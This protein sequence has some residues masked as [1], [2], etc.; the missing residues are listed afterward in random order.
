MKFTPAF[1]AEEML[2]I[3]RKDMPFALILSHRVKS[4]S[5]VSILFFQDPFEYFTSIYSCVFQAAS[6]FSFP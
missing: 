1:R 5:L 3:F 6:F 2:I 4:R